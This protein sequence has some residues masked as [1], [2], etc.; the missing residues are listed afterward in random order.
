[1]NKFLAFIILFASL[2]CA[3][4]EYKTYIVPKDSK[5]IY[6]TGEIFTTPWQAFILE[7]NY[8]IELRKDAELSDNITNLQAKIQLYEQLMIIKDLE[9]TNRE[10]VNR[11]LNMINDFNIDYMKTMKNIFGEPYKTKTQI[12]WEFPAGVIVGLATAIGSAL[13]LG[14]STGSIN[15]KQ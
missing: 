7:Y 5:V 11:N 6:P 15:F 2:I 12:H 1:M 13:I 10:A 14:L 3:T 8:G 4:N 9:L